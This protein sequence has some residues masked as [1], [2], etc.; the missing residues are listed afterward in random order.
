MDTD[1][2]VAVTTPPGRGGIGIARLSGSSA[3]SIAR[4]L[5]AIELQPRYAHLC[6]FHDSADP[7]EIIDSGIALYFPGPDSFTGEDVVE[8]QGHG[9]P[10][11]MDMLLRHCCELGARQARPGEFSERAYLHNKLDLTQAE[12]IADL[13]NSSTE[14]AARSANHSLQGRFAKEIERLV[15]GVTE[16]RSY[17]EAA[18]DFPEEEIDFLAEGEVRQRLDQLIGQVDQVTAAARQGQL[19]SEGL[20]VVLAGEPN[21]G[22][23]SLLNALS[24]RDAAIVTTQAGTTRDVLQQHIQLDGMPLQ[25]VDTAG[26]REVAGEV[27]REGIRRAWLEIEAADQVLLVEDGNLP[28]TPARREELLAE[29]RARLPAAMPVILVGNKCDLSGDPPGL[30]R[31]GELPLV[32][33]SAKT[34]QGIELLR[35]QVQHSAGFNSGEAGQFSARRR[36]LEALRRARTALDTGRTQLLASAAGEL[37]AE[38]L[39]DCQQQLGEICGTFSSDDLLSEIFSGFCI[40]K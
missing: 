26:L 10:V 1:T 32:R 2:I 22:K 17:V 20:R 40:G 12:A 27:E 29:L 30:E 14:A 5:C 28:Q 3:L 15:A 34:G 35:Q 23:S 4:Q 33:L 21:V 16:L 39:R 36:H 6:Q 31:V 24:G 13:I 18:M 38:D 7:A 25:L 37:L 19:L 8:L 9:G 11:V